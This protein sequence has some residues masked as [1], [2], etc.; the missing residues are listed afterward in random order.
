MNHQKVQELH[1]AMKKERIDSLLLL[2]T[3]VKD[4]NIYYCTGMDIEYC[5]LY[6]PQKT[7]AIFFVSEMEYGRAKKYS[8]IRDIRMYKEL[9][10]E[11]AKS[12]K[13]KE[14]IGINMRYITLAVYKGLKKKIKK[15]SWK[16]S[17][18]IWQRLRSTKTQEEIMY[19][20]KAA[21]ITD[22]IFAALVKELKMN[23][24]NYSTEKDIAEFIIK[25]A[26]KYNSI[27]AFEPI[28]A[29]GK[30]AAMPHYVTQDTALQ[31]GFC[32][33]DFGIRYKNYV[34]DMS[35]TI[36]FGKPTKEE[37][38][39][40][41]LVTEAQNAALQALKKDMRCKEI[42]AISRK[43]CKYPHG[44]GH[45]IGIE[46]HEAPSLN[47]KSKDILEENMCFTLEPGFYVPKKFGIRI[48][49]DV[50]LSKRAPV[51][52]TRSSKRLYYF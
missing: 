1:A 9:I 48:E 28:V 39:K 26:K 49:D 40:Y 17:D 4:P 50:W 3:T 8:K 33:L 32:V 20:Q 43:K 36:F 35:R 30:N 42:D 23:K 10:D 13:Q 11:V 34:S 29:S 31:H 7:P 6:I 46:V 19:L 38:A 52:L 41:A 5:G 16:K 18:D 21:A 25:T 37:Q 12:I 44:L 15:C 45:G 14:V 27:P 22:N 51:L 24:K 47:E 2:N